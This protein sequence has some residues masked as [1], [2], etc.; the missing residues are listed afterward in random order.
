MKSD[1]GELTT[2][3]I[4]IL[5]KLLRNQANNDEISEASS[6]ETLH[7]LIAGGQKFACI[8]ADPPWKYG[9]Q[10]TRA[11][12]D[13]HYPTMTP[14]EIA[15]LPVGNLAADNAH[16]HLWTTNAFLF[17][18]Q[19]IVESWGFNYKSV[20]IWAK[21]QM[22]IGNYWRVSHEFMLLGVRGNC[23]FLDRSQMSWTLAPRTGHSTKPEIFRKM[24]EKVSPRPR[25]ELFGRRL[26]DD[27]TVWGNQIARTMFDSEVSE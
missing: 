22:G 5:A 10:G 1:G 3:S 27:W 16:L 20:Q 17:E 24:I 9:N 13:N 21:P 14:D 15:S 7:G 6:A 25:L 19:K 4:L 8:Y 23:P 18:A 11:A 12:T 2:A 26:A